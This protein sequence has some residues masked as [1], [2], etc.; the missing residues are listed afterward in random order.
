[1]ASRGWVACRAARAESGALALAF[2]HSR[3]LVPAIREL[4]AACGPAGAFRSPR[5]RPAGPRQGR[6][7]HFL[8]DA[9][10]PRPAAPPVETPLE[11]RGLAEHLAQARGDDHVTLDL[12]AAGEQ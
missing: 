6:A 5:S 1:V 9:T 4:E 11:P 8:L 3:P 10:R 2:V 7:A 12:E